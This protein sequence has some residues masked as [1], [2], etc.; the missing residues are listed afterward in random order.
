LREAPLLPV[1]V[2]YSQPLARRLSSDSLR[3]DFSLLGTGKTVNGLSPK[4]PANLDTLKTTQ[5][6]P[7]SAS[8]NPGTPA[9]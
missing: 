1:R 5:S 9:L 4:L 7:V 3:P 8:G 2:C 6:S